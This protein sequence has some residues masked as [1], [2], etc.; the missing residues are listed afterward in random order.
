MENDF[1]YDPDDDPLHYNFM[2]STY[3]STNHFQAAALNDIVL[4]VDD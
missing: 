4:K 1:Y 2:D 3:R